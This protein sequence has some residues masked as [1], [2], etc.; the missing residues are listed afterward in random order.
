MSEAG[1]DS[2]IDKVI[3]NKSYGIVRQHYDE[4]EIDLESK[5]ACK[6]EFKVDPSESKVKDENLALVRYL[7]DRNLSVDLFNAHSKIH[8]GTVKVPMVTLL[9]QGKD[10]HSTGQEVDVFDPKYGKS[11]ARLQIIMTNHSIPPADPHYLK[12]KARQNQPNQK[13]HRYKH[14]ASKPL[15]LSQVGEG[16]FQQHLTTYIAEKDTDSSDQARLQ[17]RIEKFKKK[18]MQETALASQGDNIEDW[19]RKTALTHISFVREQQKT[20]V[21]DTLI[22]NHKSMEKSIEV[23]P[24][25]PSFLSVLVNNS[26]KRGDVYSVKFEDPDENVIQFPELSIVN[27]YTSKSEW[28]YWYE[29]GK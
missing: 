1:E 11:I 4:N 21:I 7:K 27:N 15:S 26:S 16:S 14:V 19:Q 23:S 20:S 29:N 24:G 10:L 25:E 28:K 2:E 22:K 9:R 3:Q 13:K 6:Y 12:N 8:F 5:K 17:L 18:K